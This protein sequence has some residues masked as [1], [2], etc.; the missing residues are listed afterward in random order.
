MSIERLRFT[1]DL[2]TKPP[3]R[4]LAV[5]TTPQHFA[6]VTYWVASAAPHRHLHPR[7]EPVG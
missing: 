2:L 4:G 1:P 7:V 3:T 5:A 6:T